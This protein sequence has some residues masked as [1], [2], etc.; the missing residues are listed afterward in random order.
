MHPLENND[1]AANRSRKK[2]FAD[3]HKGLNWPMILKNL[4]TWGGC[5]SALIK[6]CLNIAATRVSHQSFNAN[7]KNS[8]HSQN[9]PKAPNRSI[10]KRFLIRSLKN[11]LFHPRNVP[12][13][14]ITIILSLKISPSLMGPPTRSIKGRWK[15]RRLKKGFSRLRFSSNEAIQ[16]DK[17]WTKIFPVI[18]FIEYSWKHL[19][20]W[21]GRYIW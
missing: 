6:A 10:N 5:Q 18:W 7:I 19:R 13:E 21:R 3:R 14:Q 12:P 16:V 1:D 2:S 15:K 4:K 9:E 20:G 11:S 8:L 17:S